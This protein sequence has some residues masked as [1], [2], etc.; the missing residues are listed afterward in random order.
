MR[1]IDPDGMGPED[2]IIHGQDNKQW[3]VKAP[4]K[5]VDFNV[6]FNLKENKTIDIG[7]NKVMDGQRFVMGYTLSGS[8]GGG[9]TIGASGAGEVTVA[10]FTNNTYGDYN[11]TY[12]GRSKTM[13][14]GAM[15]GASVSVGVNFNFFVGMNTK[16]NPNYDPAMF[17]GKTNSLGV[18][19]DLKD[20]VGGGWNASAFTM[21][22]GW[23]GV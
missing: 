23:S 4:G 3:T 15:E 1:N 10:K 22:S 17:S 2:I 11:Y 7:L 14:A 19:Q 8:G 13:S 5:N 6:P 20:G 18:S 16:D 9:A 21:K 12:V